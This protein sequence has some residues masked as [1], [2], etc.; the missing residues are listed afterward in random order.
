MESGSIVFK[1]KV[2]FESQNAAK[3]GESVLNDL[4]TGDGKAEAFVSNA[5]GIN[6]QLKEPVHKAALLK[7]SCTNS[8]PTTFVPDY[9]THHRPPSD[10]SVTYSLTEAD[11]L[12]LDSVNF[13]KHET[14]SFEVHS[15]KKNLD[16]ILTKTIKALERLEDKDVRIKMV[17]MIQSI[18]THLAFI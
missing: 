2:K 9:V 14:V 11:Y 12:M 15:R 17:A 6:L 3:S 13:P 10:I 4:L 18:K 5:T 16:A 8:D 1:I 7:C